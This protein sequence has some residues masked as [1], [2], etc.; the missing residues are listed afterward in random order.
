MA[1][2][3]RQE[4]WYACCWCW[5]MQLGRGRQDIEYV[6]I[7]EAWM[8]QLHNDV[9]GRGIMC[10]Y[11]LTL[12]EPPWWPNARQRRAGRLV[13]D[14][15]IPPMLQFSPVTDILAMFLEPNNP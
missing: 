4:H 1:N 9:G 10:G 15:E 3:F 5:C 11:C 13:R 2:G 14:Q 12:N 7:E 8:Y 6:G